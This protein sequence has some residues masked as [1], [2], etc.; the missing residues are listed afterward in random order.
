MWQHL[1][2]PWIGRFDAPTPDR[3][4]SALSAGTTLT[5]WYSDTWQRSTCQNHIVRCRIIFSKWCLILISNTESSCQ[6]DSLMMILYSSKWQ[7][8]RRSYSEETSNQIGVRYD[9][10]WLP[11]SNMTNHVEAHIGSPWTWEWGATVRVS[12]STP[13]SSQPTPD[14]WLNKGHSIEHTTLTMQRWHQLMVGELIDTR[15]LPSN[16]WTISDLRPFSYQNY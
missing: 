7:N 1:G 6:Y 5:Q 2:R 4:T 14:I 16:S 3:A 15:L 11:S 13:D 9:T 12:Q 8:S 10:K